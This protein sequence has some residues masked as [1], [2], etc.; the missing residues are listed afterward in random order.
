MTTSGTAVLALD[1]MEVIE[2][3]FE[4]IGGEP[5]TGNDL[6]S[7]K[8]SLNLL[9][10][11]WHNFQINLWQQAFRTEDLAGTTSVPVGSFQPDT[12]VLDIVS[13]VRRET[14]SDGNPFDIPMEGLTLQEYLDLPNKDQVGP[15]IEYAVDR[16][17]SQL[18]VYLWPQA[19]TD[20]YSVHYLCL[21]KIDVISAYDVE[22][23]GIPERFHPALIKGLSYELSKK[24]VGFPDKAR[25]RL[26]R[27]Y[28]RSFDMAM[29]EDRERRSLVIKPRY[30][31][32]YSR[33]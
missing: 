23:I 9:L 11:E 5:V 16:Q 1:V 3:A 18:T 17:E 30:G 24:R 31:H 33:G 32:Q 28:L 12:D 8:R 20:D 4:P 13:A 21:I 26:E 15:P 14:G 10:R 2:E 25:D 27:D 7:A 19:N 22:T 29:A 6:R